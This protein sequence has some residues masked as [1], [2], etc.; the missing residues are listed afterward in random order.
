VEIRQRY[1]S[2]MVRFLVPIVLAA[3]VSCAR[4]I[5][6]AWPAA[7]NPNGCYVTVF[8]APQFVGVRDVWNG[9]GRWPTLDGL[10]RTRRQG[11]RDQI[12]SLHVGPAATVTLFTESGFRGNSVRMNANTSQ[13]ELDAKFSGRIESLELTCRQAAAP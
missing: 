4:P 10:Q 7:P 13:P 11:W 8:D 6:D 1:D 2:V 12:R 5:V 3:A 9:P